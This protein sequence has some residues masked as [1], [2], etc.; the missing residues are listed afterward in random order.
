MGYVLFILVTGALFIRPAEFDPALVVI[1]HYE[2]LILSCIAASFPAML[3]QL[4]PMNLKSRPITLVVIGMLLAIIVADVVRVRIPEAIQHG[5]DFIKVLIYYLLLIGLIDTPARLRRFLFSMALFALVPVICATLQYHHIIYL[6]G[7]EPLKEGGYDMDT[8][9]EFGYYR[10]RGGNT[11]V[12]ED[13]ND[14]CLLLVICMSVCLSGLTD[15]ALPALLRGAWLLPLGSIVYAF[16]LTKS[17][18]G[19][20]AL[21]VGLL[22]LMG[23][24]FGRRRMILL[25]LIGLPLIL[26]V[27][28][29]RMTSF[30]TSE[31]TGQLRVRLWF[32]GLI[33]FRHHPIFGV[34]LDQ[35]EAELGQVAH[36]SYVQCYTELGFSA[37]RFSSA[38]SPGRSSRSCAE[39]V[40]ST[41]TGSIPRR[42]GSGLLSRPRSSATRWA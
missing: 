22:C 6:P 33:L 23:A 11:S 16:S 13:P 36:N 32:E 17:R 15:P 24:R 12:F 14:L 9:E 3:A 35:Y 40:E 18:G 37:A 7:F 25:G 26:A 30:S 8:G 28:G 34:G 29:G 38:P 41:T 2:V 39:G 4:A 42:F 1:P 19:F 10:L 20:L 21:L 5:T 27:V 31:G